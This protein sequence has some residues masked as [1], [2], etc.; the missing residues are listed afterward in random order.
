ML[1]A[2]HA[3]ANKSGHLLLICPTESEVKEL[4]SKLS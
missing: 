3:F 4:N 2:L 1:S